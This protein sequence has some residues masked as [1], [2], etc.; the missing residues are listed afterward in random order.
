MGE[1]GNSLGNTMYSFYL[2]NFHLLS[3]YYEPAALLAIFAHHQGWPHCQSNSVLGWSLQ[4]LPRS[5]HK[6]RGRREEAS[7]IYAA[8]GEHSKSTYLARQ[9]EIGMVGQTDRCGLTGLGSVVDHKLPTIQRVSHPDFQLSRVTFLTIWTDPRELNAIWQH[10][11]GPEDLEK[12]VFEAVQ[13]LQFRAKCH[14]SIFKA[15]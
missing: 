5:F 14:V 9:V 11:R 15:S 4:P 3:T 13:S 8:A 12:S 2:S 7:Y 6:A 1:R 10:L